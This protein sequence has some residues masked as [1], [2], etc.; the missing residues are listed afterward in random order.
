MCVYI[1]VCVCDTCVCAWEWMYV[2]RVRGQAPHSTVFV[3]GSFLL[4]MPALLAHRWASDHWPPSA[5]SGCWDENSQS[6]YHWRP[7]PKPSCLDG[8]CFTQWASSPPLF[9]FFFF[10]DKVLYIPGFPWTL[11]PPPPTSLSSAIRQ[12]LKLT[13][14]KTQMYGYTNT[15]FK[16]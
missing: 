12:A 4:H 6:F 11:I 16:D 15:N 13:F 1:V 2:W 9:K 5:H 10:S 8:K 3:A 7:E 14:F